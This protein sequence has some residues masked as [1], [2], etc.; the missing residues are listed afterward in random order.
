MRPYQQFY[1]RDKYTPGVVMNAHCTGLIHQLDPP[2]IK[3]FIH[4]CGKFSCCKEPRVIKKTSS[5][6]IMR[7]K[8]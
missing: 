3:R 1:H 7:I 6:K 8:S 4:S 5:L 2:T